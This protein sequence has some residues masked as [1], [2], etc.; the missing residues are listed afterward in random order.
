MFLRNHLEVRL[1]ANTSIMVKTSKSYRLPA[2][3]QTPPVEISPVQ[4]HEKRRHKTV[5]RQ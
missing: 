5:Q 3:S 2:K 1:L 4:F